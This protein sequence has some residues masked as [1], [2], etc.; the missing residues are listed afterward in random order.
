[1]E[2]TVVLNNVPKTNNYITTFF[3]GINKFYRISFV[4]MVT[5]FKNLS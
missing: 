2:T 4:A 5:K 1:M 3:V